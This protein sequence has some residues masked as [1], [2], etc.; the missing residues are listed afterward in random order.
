MGSLCC[1]AFGEGDASANNKPLVLLPLTASYDQNKIDPE[2]TAA[3]Q[4][5]S[6]TKSVNAPSSA[7]QPVGAPQPAGA[8]DSL[9]VPSASSEAQAILTVP[10]ASAVNSTSVPLAFG[11]A[12]SANT[13]QSPLCSQLNPISFRRIVPI[14]FESN[15]DSKSICIGEQIM[16]KLKEDLY[17]GRNLIA[18]K[19]SLLK[20]CVVSCR[21]SRTLSNSLVQREDRLKSGGVV[22]IRFNELIIEQ[23]KSIP[24]VGLPVHQESI[25]QGADGYTHAINVDHNGRIVGA[26][27]ALSKGQQD[28]AN[29]LRAATF[30]PLPGSVLISTVAAPVVMGAIGAASPDVVFNKPID[31]NAKHRRLKGMA[32]GFASNLPGAIFVQAVVEK[33]SD[34]ILSR[35]DELMIDLSIN[36]FSKYQIAGIDQA[37]AQREVLAVRA[38]VLTPQANRLVPG[39]INPY[40]ASSSKLALKPFIPTSE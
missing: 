39:S 2:S 38:Q 24:L 3:T 21:G 14:V 9:S 34:V 19:N 11:H 10:P 8:A 4:F 37:P 18:P 7:S 1:P 31:R 25:W 27:R 6:V 20:G 26:G 23:N 32:Y 12:Q 36:G 22:Q 28:T 29:V 15:I 5:A 13:E 17:Y 40:G 30:A 16:A 35:G 33:G